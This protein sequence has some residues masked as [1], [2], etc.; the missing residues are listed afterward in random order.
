MNPRIKVGLLAHFIYALAY[1]VAFI[2]V[3]L[4]VFVWRAA[5]PPAES[6]Q[7]APMVQHKGQK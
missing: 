7:H 1:L 4:D 3:C 5:P 2:V 6:A